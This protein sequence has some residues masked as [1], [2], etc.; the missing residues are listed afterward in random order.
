[1]ALLEVRD[2][3]VRYKVRSNAFSPKRD[4]FAVN[5]VSFDLDHGETLGLVGE[6]GCGKSTSASKRRCPGR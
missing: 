3:V 4:L 5:H 1:M 2:L 6:S